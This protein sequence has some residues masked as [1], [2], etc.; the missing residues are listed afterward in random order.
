MRPDLPWDE[1]H[2]DRRTELVFIGRGMDE[3]TLRERLADC[4]LTDAEMDADPAAFENPF[5][6]EEGEELTFE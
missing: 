5:P 2:G 1:E 6:G 3:A 4:V